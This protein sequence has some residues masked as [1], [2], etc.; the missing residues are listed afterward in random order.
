MPVFLSKV[1]YLGLLSDIISR[2][3]KVAKTRPPEARLDSPAS[4]NRG[5]LR[6]EVG[7][8]LAPRLE[9]RPAST[10]VERGEE[11]CGKRRGGISID[12]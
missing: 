6:A 3:N 10:R 11:A 7:R 12:N 1:A 5:E 4:P 9:G 8:D 2:Y